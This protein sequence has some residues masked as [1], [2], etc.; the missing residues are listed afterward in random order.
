MRVYLRAI[1]CILAI[2][3]CALAQ[4][5]SQPLSKQIEQ[6]LVSIT[7][8]GETGSILQQGIGLLV[9]DEGDVIAHRSLIEG[10][11]QVQVKTS[12][13]KV[14]PLSKLIT[15]D[16]QSEMV[17]FSVGMPK[18]IAS[19]TKVSNLI[20]KVDDQVFIAALNDEFKPTVTVGVVKSRKHFAI[21]ENLEVTSQRLWPLTMPLGGPLMSTVRLLTSLD[22]RRR[23]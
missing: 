22:K 13:G 6:H 8:Y 16:I 10:A 18:G 2:S 14:Y 1:T 5:E 3:S 17:Y 4:G 11:N 19:G 9:S 15:K 21:W 12:V 23:S 20:P 7:A